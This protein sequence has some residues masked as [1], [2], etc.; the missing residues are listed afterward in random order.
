LCHADPAVHAP[1]ALV[2]LSPGA[3]TW[4][5]AQTRENFELVKRVAYPGSLQSPLLIHPLAEEAGGDFFHTGG[6]QF[7]SQTDPEWLILKAFV[8][9]EKAK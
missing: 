4:D 9:G 6:K 1:L 8:L 3:T 2:P 7:P 5:E